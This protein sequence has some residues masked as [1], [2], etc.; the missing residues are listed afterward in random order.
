MTTQEQ[1]EQ[2]VVGALHYPIRDTEQLVQ[3]VALHYLDLNERE[4]RTMVATVLLKLALRGAG[5]TT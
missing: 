4:A 3:M 1:V 5:L 2:Y